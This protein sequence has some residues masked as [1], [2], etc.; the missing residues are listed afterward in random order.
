MVKLFRECLFF[1]SIFT[2]ANLCKAQ[3]DYGYWTGIDMSKPLTKS[4]SI[5][6][7]PEVRLLNSTVH[8]DDFLVSAGIQF[9][10]L[11]WLQFELG[12]RYSRFYEADLDDRFNEHRYSVAFKPRFDFGRFTL[13]YRGQFQRSLIYWYSYGY[14]VETKDNFRSRLQVSYNIPNTKVEPFLMGEFY[15]DLTSEKDR[16]FNRIRLRVGFTYPLKK[17]NE[18]QVFGQYQSKLNTG[19]PEQSYVLGVFYSFEFRK[20]MPAT[21]DNELDQEY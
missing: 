18:I 7:S 20:F 1:V 13:T 6:L 3:T 11:K 21:T 16:E 5:S 17:R 12:Y 10:I 15:Y 4:L 14:S 2:I 8:F 19:N 9:K